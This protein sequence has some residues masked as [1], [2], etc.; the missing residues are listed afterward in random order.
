M[1]I[2]HDLTQFDPVDRGI[3]LSIGN[4][5]GVHRGHA[6]IIARARDVADRLD[7]RVVAMTF[8]PHPV[9]ILAPE[10]TPPQLVTTSEK[11]AF[12]ERCGVELCVVQRSDPAL[13]ALSAGDFIA[14]VVTHCR[15]RAFVEG[16]DFRFGRGREGSNDTLRSYA[17]R[18]GFEVH[19]L[20]AVHA[21]ELATRPIVSSSSIRQAIRDGRIT[22]ANAM[23]GRPYRITGMTSYGDGRGAGLG[24]P[25]ANLEHVPH[26]LPQDAVYAAVA[27]C[28]DDRL[29]LAAVNVGTQPTF[30]GHTRRVE[31]FL[32]DFEGDLREQPVGLHFLTRLREQVR[33][34][35]VQDLVGQIE[36]DVAA[37]RAMQPQLTQVRNYL[38]P[39]LPTVTQP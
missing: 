23:L 27:Q 8:D 35:T 2:T 10:R 33:F 20:P 34:D 9:S 28:A 36:H 17:E 38:P 32:L 11:L 26:L 1:R 24:V 5:D 6:R 14:S 13:L 21:D 39:P 18:W 4:F 7:A 12:L 19:A 22:E 37:T 29:F 25:T 30:D 31:A 15:P 16:P 3:V